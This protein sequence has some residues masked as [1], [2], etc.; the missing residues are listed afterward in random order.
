MTTALF[1]IMILGAMLAPIQLFFTA[2]AIDSIAHHLGSATGSAAGDS[3]ATARGW[4]E[5]GSPYLWIALTAVVIFLGQV[6]NPIRD[7]LQAALGDRT[8]VSVGDR[9]LAATNRWHGV[10]RFEDPKTADDLA[11]AAG[12]AGNAG[13]DLLMQGGPLIPTLLATATLCLTLAAVNPLAPVVLLLAAIPRIVNAYALADKTSSHLAVQ[14]PLARRLQYLRDAPVAPHLARD[15]RLFELGD[16]TL[17]RYDLI[18]HEVTGSLNT[19]RRQLLRKQVIG[20][21]VSEIA[22]G[23]L[24]LLVIWKATRGDLTIGDVTLYTGAIVMLNER[25]RQLGMMFGYVPMILA[26]LP[27]LQRILDAPTDLPVQANPARLTVPLQEGLVVDRVTFAYPNT[28]RPILKDV[29][30][31]LHPGERLALVGHNGAG[32]TTLVKLMLRLYDPDVERI[33]LNGIDL[34][35]YDPEELRH[36]YSVIFQDFGHYD[37]TARENIALGDI[38]RPHAD[39]ELMDAAAKAGAEP[40]IATLDAGLNTLLGR[41]FGGRELSGGE[42][43]KIALARAFVRDAPIL[44]LDEPTAA[45]DVRAEYDVYQRFADLTR[46]RATLLISHRFS[47]VRMADRILVLDENRLV[48]DGSH[49]ELM[50]QRGVYHR[51]YS[52][53]AEHYVDLCD[54]EVAS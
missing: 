40:V 10:A 54:A 15:F 53:Q 45:L 28:T 14:S 36:A 7:G 49:A 42:W 8:T 16:R 25:I 47:T 26:F 30:F 44:V 11:L 24:V 19:L 18:W 33:T 22:A 4:S 6:L 13:T 37:F 39:G 34:R 5:H 9:L 23:G 43:Q 27:S 1:A 35:D 50:A 52:A 31:T 2:T 12:R 17:Q 20:V 32:K 21:A 51:L 3:T 48:E 41:R 46:G 38:D 29:S